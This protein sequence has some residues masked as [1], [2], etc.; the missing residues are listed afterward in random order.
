MTE[1]A[2]NGP[3][4]DTWTVT[5]HASAHESAPLGTGL[6]LD[7]RRVLTCAHVV[8]PNG[9]PREDM[10]IAFPK[11]RH[12][13]GQRRRVASVRI[14]EP[15]DVMDFAIVDL[16]EP[17]PAGVTPA[18]LRC[19]RPVDLVGHRWWAFGFGRSDRLGSAAEGTID[20]DL[21]YGWVRLLTQSRYAV[22]PG[23]SGS[24]LWSREY[25]AVV[26]LVGQVNERGDGRALTL[27]QANASL[28]AAGL[29]TLAEWSLPAAGETALSAWGWTLTDDPEARQH[30]RPRARGVAVGSERGDRFRGRTAALRAITTWLA[31]PEPDRTVLLITGSPG[32]GKSAVLGRVVTTADNVFAAELPVD[33]DAIR[34]TVGSV[35]CAVHVKGKTAR[36][37]ALEIARAASTALPDHARDLAPAVRQAL[38]ERPCQKFNIIIDALDEATD[39]RET[40][41]IIN[42][43]VLPLAETCS[44]LGVQIVVGTR[45]RDDSGD[46]LAAMSSLATIIDLDTEQYFDEDDLTAYA[47]ATLQLT[48]DERPANPYADITVAEPVA[49]RIAGLAER[50]FLVAGLVAR[51]HGMHDRQSVDPTTLTFTP[52]VA[53]ALNDYIDR[54]P[55]VE[56]VSALDALT[57]LAFAQAPGL[58]LTLWPLLMKA[59]GMPVTETALARFARS[60]AANFLVE[61]SGA[62]GFHTYRLYHQ[63][64]NDALL[65]RRQEYRPRGDDECVITEA[66]L[67]HGRAAGWTNAGS[68][69]RR[70]LPYHADR[71]AMVDDLLQVDEYLLYADL[72]RLIPVARN[73]RAATSRARLLYLTPQAISATAEQRAGLFNI[74]QALERLGPPLAPCPAGALRV[75]WARA[76]P[77]GERTICEGHT[78]KVR[79]VCPVTA[80]GRPLLASAGHDH[81]V[82]IWDPVTGEQELV[83][84]GHHDRVFAVCAVTVGDTPLLTS[85]SADYTVRLW[86]PVTG[87]QVN[88]MHG[89]HGW[90][91]GLCSITVDGQDLVASASDD[92]T[93]RLWD[94][95]TGADLHVL[96]GHTNK[97]KA[98]C[99]IRGD[100]ESLVASASDDHTV[101]IW[102]PQTGEPR[103]VLRGH[104]AWVVAVCTAMVEGK[105]LLASIG[106]DYDGIRLWD[107]I[108]GLQWPTVGEYTYAKYTHASGAMCTI[109]RGDR[110]LFAVASM[111]EISLWDLATGEQA[112]RLD[113]HDE[114]ILGLCTV[115]VMGK[116]MLA[117]ASLD[118]TVRIWDLDD[119]QQQR[120]V[121]G[122]PFWIFGLCPVSIHGRL[123]LAT[124]SADSDKRVCLWDAATGEQIRVLE[125]HTDQVHGVCTVTIKGRNLLATGGYD[126][127]VRLWEP[128]T[129]V[130]VRALQINRFA[131]KSLCTVTVK[132]R[133]LLAAGGD[134]WVH[135]WDPKK[136]KHL[137]TL[138]GHTNWVYGVCELNV[139][140]RPLLASASW[141]EVIIWD[142]LTGR[143]EDGI[144]LG[145]GQMRDV[146]QIDVEGRPLLAIAMDNGTVALW[147]LQAKEQWG[148]ISGH[149][150]AVNSVHVI[151]LRGRSLLASAGNDRWV[152]LSDPATR[153]T[154]ATL[155][156]HSPAHACTQ[157]AD[158]LVIGLHS[159]LISIDLNT[160]LDG[161]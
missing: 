23:F 155:P 154:V 44:D 99:E 158:S 16:L 86:D 3:P 152:H 87:N 123:Q 55:S 80:D 6:V 57:C 5:V 39:T 70:S 29:S 4:G 137:R 89:H 1:H 15:S 59:L 110:T 143:Q 37:V 38:S 104:T 149:T 136:G 54:A 125:G 30:W 13:W 85:G 115:S 90:V 52:S 67:R 116:T 82:R 9:I 118:H 81:S 18:P 96:R 41:L 34:A 78:N 144:E 153:G 50:N 49:R 138:D 122:D 28:P 147:D 2:S 161:A 94:L 63:A 139:G 124:V 45:R 95:Q 33:D 121:E 107:P 43:I 24:G 8:A 148:S 56:D 106:T 140:G 98:V 58:P 126:K 12:A 64:L 76:T 157:I 51:T 109:D 71:A 75:L 150:N 62:E 97:V 83:L 73:A 129:G 77:Q 69:L 114:E 79:A 47:L 130:Q 19:P 146:C 117:S 111:R 101:R 134:F 151:N 21:G 48:G 142:P 120:A 53:S 156:V 42:T 72:R 145:S 14:G 108:T 141:N 68:Y 40:R 22:E 25:Q 27:Y 60:S 112:G 135:L 105:P 20:A 127:V 46:L 91:R 92:H 100:G 32:V 93:V 66:L 61:I 131:P 74:T 102:D 159:G 31:R 17:V 113:G 11:S 26:G 103:H 88:T 7:N 84:Q 35:A 128:E 36:D 10:W 65:R 133:Q 160:I 119:Y 132:G